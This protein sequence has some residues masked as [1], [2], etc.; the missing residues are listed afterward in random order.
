MNK[1]VVYRNSLHGKLFM[2]VVLMR[3]GVPLGTLVFLP[4]LPRMVKAE[5]PGIHI[6]LLAL[7]IKTLPN[8]PSLFDGKFLGFF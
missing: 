5:L 6:G 7:S 2:A 4:T 3:Q 1:A 8:S